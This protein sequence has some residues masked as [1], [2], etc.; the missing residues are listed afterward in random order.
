MADDLPDF[1]NDDVSVTAGVAAKTEGGSAA[2][3]ATGFKDFLLKPEIMQGIVECGFEHPSEVQHACIPQAVLGTDILCQAKAGMGKTAVF[4]VT[5]LQLVDAA[6]SAV[7]VLVLGHTRELAYQIEHEFKRLGKHLAGVTVKSVIGGSPI[8]ND[9]EA[10]KN[11]PAILV[12][13]PGRVLGLLRNGSLKLDKLT[14]FVL[15]EADR[16]ID[17]LELR[18]DVQQ[19]FIK[20]PKKKQVMM[21]SAT[22][23]SDT[24]TICKK[25]M[26]TPHEILV[27]SETK[28][29]LHG[30]LQYYVKLEEKNKNKKLIDLLDTLEFNQVVIFVKNVKRALALDGILRDCNFPSMTLHQL[31]EEFKHKAKKTE[32]PNATHS[33]IQRLQLF[34]DFHKRILVTTDLFG[35]GMD[36]ERLNIVINYDIPEDDIMYLH[37]VGRCGRFGTKGLAITF[38]SSDED[39]K[40]LAKV[41]SRFEVNLKELPVSIDT[42]SYLNA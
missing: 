33:R 2:I 7:R 39:Q 12:G 21:F 1:E 15:D 8:E 14:H 10:L 42:T 29:T 34:K 18:R 23:S 32:V 22:L 4:V 9:K 25:F 41:Q 17:H 11:P 16:C 38:V 37:R 19:V 40:T 3:R 35:R 31:P 24:R 6:E 13:T 28:L 30:L 36:V 26:Q 27:E 20:T 5:C